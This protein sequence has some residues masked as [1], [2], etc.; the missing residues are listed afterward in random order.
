MQEFNIFR[1]ESIFTGR[2]GE[3]FKMFV[4]RLT[5][6]FKGE[7]KTF[8]GDVRKP[9]NEAAKHRA[10]MPGNSRGV[11]RKIFSCF[12]EPGREMGLFRAK[13]NPEG[14]ILPGDVSGA[15]NRI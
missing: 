11:F 8:L 6:R 4:Q 10:D 7:I 1:G 3:M 15:G 2:E 14:M 9:Y 12:P 5:G 13:E